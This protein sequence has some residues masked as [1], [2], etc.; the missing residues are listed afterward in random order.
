MATRKLLVTGTVIFEKIIAGISRWHMHTVRS[1]LINRVDNA[2]INVAS[3]PVFRGGV[4]PGYEANIN[5][6]M[7]LPSALVQV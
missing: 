2:H 4:W 5:V 6:D 1:N 7:L 3:F